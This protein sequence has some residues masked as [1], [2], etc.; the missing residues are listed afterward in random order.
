MNFIQINGKREKIR[1]MTC[2]KKVICFLISKDE[3]LKLAP[4]FLICPRFLEISIPQS[5]LLKL[6][7][8]PKNDG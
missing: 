4:D 1:E 2:R 8:H 7:K 6:L 5:K 3:M